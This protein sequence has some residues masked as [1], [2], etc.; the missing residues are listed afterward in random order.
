MQ[1]AKNIK[2]RH[3]E[4]TIAA[5]GDS[6]DKENRPTRAK[7][8]VPIPA[9]EIGTIAINPAVAIAQEIN[10]KLYANPVLLKMRYV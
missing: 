4:R 1:F 10:T 5:S 6:P 3:E 2:S 9:I 8:L 7:S